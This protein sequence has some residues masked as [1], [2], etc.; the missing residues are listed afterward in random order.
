ML[1]VSQLNP[2]KT[3]LVFRGFVSLKVFVCY[4]R[5]VRTVRHF[6]FCI[7]HEPRA[8]DLLIDKQELVG[9]KVLKVNSLCGSDTMD[10]SVGRQFPTSCKNARIL[11]KVTSFMS[12]K[13]PQFP[14]DILSPKCLHKC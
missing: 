13:T 6:P 1:E 14:G 3:A 5:S 4:E 2:Q 8:M 10:V 11:R 9:N 7:F 12:R